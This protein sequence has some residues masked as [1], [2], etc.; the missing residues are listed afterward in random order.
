M[1]NESERQ[2][3]LPEEETGFKRGL[4]PQLGCDFWKE[5]GQKMSEEIEINESN[6]SEYFRDVRNCTP[7][8]GEVIAQYTA[9][10]EFVEGNEKRQVISLLN[11]TENKMEATAQVMRK[12]LFAS[13]LDAYRVPRMMAED[14][15]S[16]MTEDEVASK[17]YKFTLEMFFY[18]RPENVPKDDP[19]WS[20]ISVLNLEDFLGKK[21]GEIQAK[22]LSGEEADRLNLEFREGSHE[23]EI[24]QSGQTASGADA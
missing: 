20:I 5:E 13:E 2:G 8:R 10:A 3:E 23:T 22:I 4:G 18:A 11:S 9:A 7:A 12:L 14:M 6:F 24:T 1:K 16:G 21:D 15:I 19:H 17:P